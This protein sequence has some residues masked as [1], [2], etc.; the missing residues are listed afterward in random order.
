MK[1]YIY[2]YTFSDGKVYIGQT[3]RP[4][5]QRDREHFDKKIGKANPKFWEA[6]QKLGKPDFVIIETIEEGRVQDLVKALN[7]AETKY[8]EYY[9]SADSSFGYNVRK[10]AYVSIPPDKV[11]EAEF[12]RIWCECAEQWYPIFWEVQ[13]KCFNTFEPLND[14]EK[15]FCKDYLLHK[16]NIFSAEL[17][18]FKI[19]FDN[20]RNNNSDAQFWIDEALDFAEYN[21]CNSNWDR[22]EQYIEEHKEQILK[23]NLPETTIVQLDK[24]W[25]IVK[26]YSSSAEVREAMGRSNITNIFNVLEG[27][28]K[29]AYG[30]IWRYK[31]DMPKDTNTT[32]GKQFYLDFGE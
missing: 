13:N 32:S 15:K 17:I 8:I 5:E 9:N 2:K 18:D 21:F 10:R 23:D 7:E 3:R 20:L 11:L 12:T 24:R 30:Y 26:E 28:Q 22:I 16:D 29:T 27:K 19:D 4:V 1:G 31:K 14:I 6:Y 25:N